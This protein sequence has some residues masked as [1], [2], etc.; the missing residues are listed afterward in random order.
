M[1][2]KKRTP[3]GGRAKT[4]KAKAVKKAPKNREALTEQE[5]KVHDLIVQNGASNEEIAKA[6]RADAESG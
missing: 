3:K 2:S 5:A 6:M 1:A 4:T